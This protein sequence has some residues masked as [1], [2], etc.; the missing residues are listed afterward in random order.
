MAN[1]DIELLERKKCCCCKCDKHIAIS[2]VGLTLSFWEIILA[3]VYNFHLIGFG[4]SAIGIV[5]S[6]LYLYFNLKDLKQRSGGN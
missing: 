6:G 5:C 2:I 1:N 4:F 3:S